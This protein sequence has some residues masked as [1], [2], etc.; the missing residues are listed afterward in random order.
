M[1]S[2]G[3]GFAGTAGV[4]A[5]IPF[6]GWMAGIAAAYIDRQFILP[7]I[8]GK[9]RGD[10][11]STELFGVTST[12][13][14]PGGA[15]VCAYG[16]RVRVPTRVLWADRKQ[17]E[18]NAGG[19]KAGTVP[20]RRVFFD[21]MIALNERPTR[22]MIHLTGN[23]A[24]IV[25]ATRN[26]Y[27]VATTGIT[28]T[29]GATT[30]TLQMVDNF[31]P[32]WLD[33]FPDVGTVV[34]LSNFITAA[35]TSLNLGYW[36]VTAV[37]DHTD[38]IPSTLTLE[39][40]SG[41]VL[42]SIG[43]T[44]AGTSAAPATVT[45]I[46][47]VLFCETASMPYTNPPPG[48]W[49]DLSGHFTDRDQ[50]ANA[51]PPGTNVILE[52]FSAGTSIISG[53]ADVWRIGAVSEARVFVAQING[54]ISGPVTTGGTNNAGRIRRQ[55]AQSFANGMLPP[56]FVPEDHYF[57]GSESQDENPLLA[58]AL[59]GAGMSPGYRGI[60]YQALDDFFAND[61]G[62]QLPYSLTALLEV[63]LDMT[64]A[65]CCFEVLRRGNIPASAINVEGIID[66]PLDGFYLEGPSPITSALQPLLIAKSILGQERDGVICLFSIENAD[67][68]QIANGEQFTD[69]GCVMLGDSREDNKI[70]VE[71]IVE[72]DLPT[73]VGVYFQDPD[74]AYTVNYEQFGLRHPG[75]DPT[76][77]H[78]ELNLSKVVLT[79]KQAADLATTTLRRAHINSRKFRMVLPA[80]YIDLLENDLITVTDDYGFI[81]TARIVQRDIGADWR[82]ALVCIH[83][84][85]DLAVSGSPVQPN[86]VTNSPGVTASTDL[87]VVVLDIPALTNDEIQVPGVKIAVGPKQG[88]LFV[89]ATIWES[90]DGTTFTSRGPIG[91]AAGIGVLTTEM[92]GSDPAESHGTNVLFVDDAI[93]VQVEFDS[94]GPF[95]IENASELEI[96][97]NGKNQVAIVDIATGEVEIAAFASATFVD[98]T[99]WQLG[100][101]YRGIRGTRVRAHAAGSRMVLLAPHYGNGIV[102]LPYPGQSGPQG[103]I[104]KIVPSGRS[105][106]EAI[107]VSVASVWRNV[108]PFPVR[109]VTK[110]IGSAPFPIRISFDHWTRV[111]LPLGEMLNPYPRMDPTEAYVVDLYDPAGLAVRF[112]KYVNPPAGTNTVRDK[113]VDF[114]ASE[115]TQAGYTPGAA[116]QIYVDVRQ[117]GQFGES[118]IN[119]RLL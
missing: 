57:N 50:I 29:I 21:T 7:R 48:F 41:Q 94:Y 82:V 86:S 43:P 25:F 23:D 104:Y 85:V 92:E 36:K 77:N 22:R 118:P 28:V 18:E 68:V 84:D 79:R 63:E 80:R 113:W 55:V 34:A 112:R 44:T 33:K 32:S 83:E 39:P 110:T 9:R 26:I 56:T 31:E 53:V 114:S 99:T 13:N 107:T 58:A 51:F 76:K 54:F 8:A 73:S 10:A 12:P 59:G 90:L 15:R 4:F 116:L 70:T 102:H 106:D 96:R 72:D 105:I 93:V 69:L 75:S 74:N 89:G 81:I 3:V 64:W 71:D 117:V 52:G 49:V 95:G 16:R 27:D 88:G 45:R 1:A 119:L 108:L 78:Q 98:G 14:S 42:A 111:V 40:Y 2:V 91:T 60:A 38:E 24:M 37:T 66:A 100:K 47:D 6:V 61:F 30:V 11:A 115:L 97:Y 67:S 17:R 19:S 20:V 62:E 103:I 46:D 109:D 5:G 87:N 65:R 101:F 35:G